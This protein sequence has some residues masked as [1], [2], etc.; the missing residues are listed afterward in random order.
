MELLGGNKSWMLMVGG[1]IAL[2]VGIHFVT[3]PVPAPTKARIEEA[4]CVYTGTDEQGAHLYRVKARGIAA[5]PAD[6]MVNVDTVELGF[7][8][9][10]QCIQWGR[11]CYRDPAELKKTEWSTQ[12]EFGTVK[13]PY[14]LTLRA[15]TQGSYVTVGRNAPK[16]SQMT[17]E[18]TCD[19]TGAAEPV[20]AGGAGTDEEG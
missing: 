17:K 14:T 5:G 6:V 12:F 8:V 3:R 9:P 18:V 4:S 20:V 2:F 11:A 16:K 13:S 10:S 7:P 19:F 15:T 1:V